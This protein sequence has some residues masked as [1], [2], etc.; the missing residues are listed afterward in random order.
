MSAPRLEGRTAVVI[1]SSRGIGRSIAEAYAAEG[2]TVVC[3]ARDVDALVSLFHPDAVIEDLSHGI[4][5]TDG[6]LTTSPANPPTQTRIDS[7]QSES[8]DFTTPTN[9]LVVNLAAGNNTFSVVSLANNFNTPTNTING[10]ANN[11]VV[12]QFYA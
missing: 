7:N 1:G 12:Q 11:D 4:I 2:A 6:A 5:I 10:N 8:V 3:V 9:S